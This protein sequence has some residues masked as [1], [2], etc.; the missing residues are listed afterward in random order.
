MLSPNATGWPQYLT[1][2]EGVRGTVS[3][4]GAAQKTCYEGGENPRPGTHRTA[5]EKRGW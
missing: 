4:E 2:L 3:D 1:L 5:E